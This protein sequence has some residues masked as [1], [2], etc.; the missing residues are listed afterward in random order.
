MSE[1]TTW[2]LIHK[3]RCSTIGE[4]ICMF[5]FTF[6]LSSLDFDRATAELQVLVTGV[7]MTD[8]NSPSRKCSPPHDSTRTR[9]HHP[10]SSASST[11]KKHPPTFKLQKS[12]KSGKSD[13]GTPFLSVV[14]TLAHTW[15]ALFLS[16][17]PDTRPDTRGQGTAL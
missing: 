13:K 16:C 9:R 6:S 14:H 11:P 12:P 15:L 7:D 2:Q 4:C 10:S 17:P 1:V 3:Q 5:S 8:G